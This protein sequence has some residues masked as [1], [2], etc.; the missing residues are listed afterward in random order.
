MTPHEPRRPVAEP[1]EDDE[2]FR[3]RME[4]YENKYEEYEYACAEEVDR[5]REERDD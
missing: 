2:D 5:Q 1:Y 4:E 3:E